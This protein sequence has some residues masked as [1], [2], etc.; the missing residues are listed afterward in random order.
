MISG[1]LEQP[2]GSR[3]GGSEAGAGDCPIESDLPQLSAGD[4]CGS[5]NHPAI[6]AWHL[7]TNH[8]QASALITR[9]RPPQCLVFPTCKASIRRSVARSSTASWAPAPT[10]RAPCWSSPAPAPGKTNTLAHRVAH[11]I[12]NGADPGRILLLTFSR[13]A[14]AEMERR[15]ERIIAAALGPTAARG[16]HRLVRHL[17]RRR[18]PPAAQPRPAIGLDPSFTIHDR[19]DSADLHEPGAARARPLRQGPPLSAQG[20]L[21]CHLLARRE[22]RRAAG[23]RA[24]Q[25]VSLVRRV[26]GR[27]A[28]SVRGLRRGQAAPAGARLRRSAALLG[29]S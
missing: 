18:R 21:P 13:R 12:V 15:A 4:R 5:L 17:P 14:A 11:L 29:A 7:G 16:A 28:R 25:A 23:S 22:C 24:A 1:Q 26:E 10:S 20:H 3:L 6:D 8:D 27:A 9:A 19:E 2:R